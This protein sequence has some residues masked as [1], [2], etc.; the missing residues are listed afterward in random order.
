MAL[1]VAVHDLYEAHVTYTSLH[2]FVNIQT[3]LYPVQLGSTPIVSVDAK[4]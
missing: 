1:Y 3:G 2:E 4:G